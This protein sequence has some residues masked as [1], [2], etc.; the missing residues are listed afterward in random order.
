[1]A[2]RI[3]RAERF[4]ET[5]ELEKA[6][7]V[8]ESFEIDIDCEAIAKDYNKAIN[9]ITAAQAKISEHP[10]S[11]QAQE[12]FGNAI[13]MLFEVVF[14]VEQAKKLVDFFDGAYMEMALQVVP[15]IASD[16]SPMIEKAVEDMKKRA[17]ALYRK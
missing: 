9:G 13:V 4:T 11:E 15:Y 2:I 10:Q 14:G 3:K 6:G 1:M 16:I 5:V 12:A 7:E 17:E 8:V